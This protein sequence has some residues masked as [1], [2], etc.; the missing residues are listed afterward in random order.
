MIVA[1]QLLSH[2]QLFSTP[3]T[4]AHQASLSFMAENNLLIVWN[5]S[6]SNID[7]YQIVVT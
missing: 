5:L 2:V 7:C 1:I 6:I 3:W 4:V